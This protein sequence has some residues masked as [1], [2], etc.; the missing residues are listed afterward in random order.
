M[1]D[2]LV[3]ADETRKKGILFPPYITHPSVDVATEWKTEGVA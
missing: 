3:S 2:P 1:A